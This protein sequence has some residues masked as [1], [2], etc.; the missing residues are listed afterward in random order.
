VGLVSIDTCRADHLSVYG[1][2]RATSP[3]LAELAARGV[4]FENAFCHVPDTT[5]S[6][7]SLFTSTHPDRHGSANGVPLAGGLATLAE[8]LRAAGLRTAGFVSGATLLAERS[9]LARGFE[10]WDDELTRI[11]SNGARQPTE[12]RAEETTDRA[13]AWLAGL[14][15][16]PFFVFVHYYD[17]HG[18]YEPPPPYDALFA[19]RASGRRL[20][21]REIPAYARIPGVDRLEDYVARY[22]GEIRYVDDQ[23]RRLERALAQA[24][25][26]ASTL[27][28][29]TADHGEELGEHGHHFAHGWELYEAELR[30]PLLFAAPGRLPEGRR[31]PGLARSIDVAPS[32]LALLGLSAPPTF[33]G[34]DLFAPSP[35]EGDP[36]LLARTTKSWTYLRL[37]TREDYR[38]WHALRGPRWKL[39]R[40]ED[41]SARR[42]YDLARDP[43]ELDDRAA[44]EPAVLAELERVLDA[45][46]ARTARAAGGPE[47]APPDETWTEELQALGYVR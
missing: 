10:L 20:S 8:V 19:D 45:R 36:L 5:P 16:A 39:L 17:P 35:E 47:A 12:R 34:R 30:V 21:E 2:P 42:L 41:G 13:L 40:A 15:G 27:W 11:G 22:D 28:V 37:R 44:A 31:E 43:G 14:D 32:V 38:D 6:H 23:L 3:F 4:L 9:G 33:E 7:A 29:V 26:G 1:Y 24:G 18:I 25:R 46:L